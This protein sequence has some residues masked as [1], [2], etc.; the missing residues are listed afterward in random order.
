M[1]W[2]LVSVI[3]ILTI[4]I[5]YLSWSL[6]SWTSACNSWK[7]AYERASSSEDALGLELATNGQL[8][9]EL[10]DR[11][12]N[13]FIL[14]LPHKSQGGD[15]IVE[16]HIC[17]IRTSNEVTQILYTASELIRRDITPPEDY[18]SGSGFEPP[19]DFP[20]PPPSP[21]WDE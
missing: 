3:V 19:E 7:D 14:L 4:V 11:P 12:N 9:K 17:N 21:L 16:T 5:L 13:H 20:P 1:V 10:R 15:S 18:S 2:V 8:F 6:H